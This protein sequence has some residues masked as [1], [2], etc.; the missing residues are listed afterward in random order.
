[1]RIGKVSGRVTLS[2]SHDSLMGGRFLFI[3][4]QDR[5]ALSGAARKT[6]EVLIAYDSLGAGVGETVAFTE[7]REACMPFYPEKKVPIDALVAAILD[8]VSVDLTTIEGE[9]SR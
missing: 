4:V 7:S 5:F 8:D 9:V 2:R 6:T 3:E 1:M